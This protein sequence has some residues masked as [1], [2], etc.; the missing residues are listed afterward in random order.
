MGLTLNRAA[1]EMLQIPI[2][3]LAEQQRIAAT[4]NQVEALRTRRHEALAHLDELIQSIFLDIFGDP[5]QNPHGWTR[6]RLGELIDNIDSGRS[7]VCLNRSARDGEWGVLKLGAVTSCRYDPGQNKALPEVAESMKRHEVKNGDLLF[8]RKNTLDLVATWAIVRT[9]PPRM[10]PPDLI[11]RMRLRP[12]SGAEAVY[13]HQLM[14]QPTKRRLV[15]LLAAGSAGP[16]PNISKAKLAK[17]PVEL[18]PLRLQREFVRQVE[19]IERLKE[20]QRAQLR[21]PEGRL[22]GTV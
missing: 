11:F 2:P 18:P 12:S 15:Q 13:V 10:L 17:V 7:P 3:G 19:A 8:S 22:A 6:R 5:V 16:M 14:I 20:R 9:T 1:L 21:V 4:L